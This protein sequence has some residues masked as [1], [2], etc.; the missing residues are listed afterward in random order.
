MDAC[1]Q[2]WQL[3]VLNQIQREQ[4]ERTTRHGL[5]LKT[6]D[7]NLSDTLPS[8]RPHLL[9]LPN[10][11]TPS[12]LWVSGDHSDL[13]L[14][15]FFCCCDKEFCQ[16]HLK[17]EFVLAYGSRGWPVQGQGRMGIDSSR[18]QRDHTQDTT[19]P[20]K[21][22]AGYRYLPYGYTHKGSIHSPNSATIWGSSVQIH[23][24]M[25]D[26]PHSNYT[27]QHF[28]VVTENELASSLPHLLIFKAFKTSYRL[29]L[30]ECNY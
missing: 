13:N 12:N 1:G 9:I 10:S 28:I 5:A 15:F 26:F 16:K 27:L 20:L 22:T 21:P 24:L 25:G 19:S 17:E 23:K 6:S 11:A 7:L 30:W 18:K 29:I 2:T 8:E 4:I 3:R 14:R